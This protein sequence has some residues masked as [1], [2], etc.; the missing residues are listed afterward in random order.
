M[1]AAGPSSWSGGFSSNV[2]KLKKELG[3]SVI[4]TW[5]WRVGSRWLGAPASA[6]RIWLNKHKCHTEGLAAALW[7]LSR[8]LCFGLCPAHPFT[9]EYMEGTSENQPQSHGGSVNGES[10]KLWNKWFC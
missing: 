6:L 4:P 7:S 10:F 5:L 9:G 2:S 8:V 1:G 3:N